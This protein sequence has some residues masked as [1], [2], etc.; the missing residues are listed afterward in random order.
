MKREL[1][2]ASYRMPGSVEQT[3]FQTLLKLQHGDRYAQEP[4]W[5]ILT[6]FGQT[7][8]IGVNLGDRQCW[9]ARIL[10]RTDVGKGQERT[11][12][13]RAPDRENWMGISKI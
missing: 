12:S 3:D 11:I 8:Q 5:A 4:H 13:G 9:A 2:D 6:L 1:S 7:H 10:G